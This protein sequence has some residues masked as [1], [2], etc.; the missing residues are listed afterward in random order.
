LSLLRTASSISALTLL[1]RVLGL[2]RDVFTSHLLGTS[3]VNGALQ[4]AWMLPNMLRRLFGEGA[5]S[6]AFV[7]AFTR[8]LEREG[9]PAA[10]ALLAS[11]GGVL[12]LALGLL[13]AVVVAIAWL[14]P[15]E[16]WHL[17]P[18]P[19]DDAAGPATA[20]EVGALLADLLLILFP[21]AL[22][23]CVLAVLAGALNVFGRFAA[24]A[25]TPALLN[26]FG[27]TGLAVGWLRTPDDLPAIAK[28]V[29][30]ALLAGGLAQLLLVA[31]PLRRRGCLPAPR[32]PRPGDGA[33]EVFRAMGPTVLG[34]SLVQL[35]VF[36]D[37]GLAAWLIGTGANYHIFL[38]NRLLLFPHSL[39]ALPLTTAV[40]PRLAAHA[41]RDDLQSLRAQLDRAAGG[42]LFLAIPATVGL[43]LVADTLLEV[44]FVHGRYTAADAATTRWTTIALVA[45][46]PALG[47]SQL[48]ARALYALGDTRTP[49][50]I[51]AWLV[52]LNLTLNLTFLLVLGLGVAGLTA[53][54]S[55]C[56][57]VNAL[58]LRRAIGRRAPGGARA[59]PAIGRA[60]LA[61]AAMAAAILALRALLPETQSRSGTA[62]LG[63]VV[64]VAAGIA[65]YVLAQIALRSP[66]LSLVRDRLRR[67]RG[68]V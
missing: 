18:A 49:A 40:F 58:A 25:A 14:L 4:L 54:T 20:R 68:R 44:A 2:C 12:I 29:A 55:C 21:Y 50:R 56:T 11:V 13:V 46:L 37:Q 15:P 67:R 63:L 47:A 8:R 48:A 66:E 31:I 41:S 45:G 16:A 24:A 3:W 7:P 5:L 35:N 38:A 33:T 51:S 27:L 60:L 10:R 28:T 36:I 30:I 43:A 61:S 17:D 9:M 62:I 39:V 23:I 22:P 65:V 19:G 1:S 42:I 34:M 6:A 32:W 64:P 26:V 53:A 57:Y 59:L 52:L